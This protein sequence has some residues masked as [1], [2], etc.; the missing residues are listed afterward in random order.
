MNAEYLSTGYVD[1]DDALEQE[2]EMPEDPRDYSASD[3]AL[4]RESDPARQRPIGDAA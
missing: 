2:P 4:G 3:E 1:D